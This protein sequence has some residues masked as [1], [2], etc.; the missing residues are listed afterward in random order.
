MKKIILTLIALNLFSCSDSY[1]NVRSC[2]DDLDSDSKIGVYKAL[3]VIKT[4]IYNGIDLDPS[5]STFLQNTE[6]RRDYVMMSCRVYSCN[7]G[8]QLVYGIRNAFFEKKKDL[9]FTPLF[10]DSSVPSDLCVEQERVC[11]SPFGESGVQFYKNIDISKA[12]SLTANAVATPPSIRDV[13]QYSQCYLNE[14]ECDT[15]DLTAVEGAMSGVKY[16]NKATRSYGSCFATACNLGYSLVGSA[17]V[18]NAPP[19]DPCLNNP[20]LCMP[21]IPPL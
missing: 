5:S 6:T 8:Y 19:A 18:V 17:C 3:E 11:N 21:Q 15:T 10:S 7:P 13:A 1:T 9:N 14:V 12:F 4:D 2:E 16:F 20:I